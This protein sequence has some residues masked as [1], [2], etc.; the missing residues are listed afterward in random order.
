MREEDSAKETKKDKSGFVYKYGNYSGYYGYRLDGAGNDPRI[1]LL[2]AEWFRGKKILDIGCNT[3]VLS[4]RIARRFSVESIHGVDIDKSLITRATR[5]LESSVS[6]TEAGSRGKEVPK[7]GTFH[8]G[9]KLSWNFGSS[10]SEAAPSS[11]SVSTP[12]ST[13]IS[14]HE[15]AVT[16]EAGNYLTMP[17][18]KASYDTILWYA[19]LF[20]RTIMKEFARYNDGV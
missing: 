17:T 6:S 10:S 1:D 13:T 19:C 16:F 5:N 12:S 15:P 9:G 14:A 2:Q 3:G 11:S 4:I 7:R 20:A 8:G 18:E